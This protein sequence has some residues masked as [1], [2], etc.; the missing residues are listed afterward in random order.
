MSFLAPP[1]PPPRISLDD[2]G[3]RRVHFELWQVLM[4]L[5]TVVVTAWFVTFGPWQ[6]ILALMIAK[7]VL[8]AILVQGVDYH[9]TPA[10]Q[11]KRSNSAAWPT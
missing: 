7:H 5:A 8:V 1:K 6:A 10:G 3:L 4:A 2:E 11:G 9:L